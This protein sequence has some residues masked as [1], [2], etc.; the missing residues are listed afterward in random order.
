MKRQWSLLFG[1]LFAIIVA[2]FAVIN[3]EPV[4]VNYL[5]GKSEWP[6]VLVILI[7]VLLGGLMIGSTGIVKIF[8]LQRKLKT[9]TKE[10]V[11]LE[12]KLSKYEEMQP[13]V[14]GEN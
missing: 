7:S 11:E 8:S 14:E 2:V 5:F 1:I 9:V 13:V 12:E 4:T 6:L 3:V 10:K